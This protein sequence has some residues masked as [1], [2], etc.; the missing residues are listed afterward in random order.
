[1]VLRTAEQAWQ[2][3]A[4]SEIGTRTYCTPI[5]PPAASVELCLR[6]AQRLIDDGVPA[7]VSC[8]RVLVD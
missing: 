2:L 4:C 8:A 5:G 7:R 3:G 1:M 6:A